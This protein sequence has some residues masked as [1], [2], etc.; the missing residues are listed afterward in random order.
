MLKRKQGRSV[1]ATPRNAR[2]AK[3]V[4]AVKTPPAARR[5][6]VLPSTKRKATSEVAPAA[7]GKAVTP[8][9]VETAKT[10]EKK[11]VVSAQLTALTNPTAGPV[12][13]TETVK[14]LL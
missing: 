14:T 10:D 2:S 11:P 1:P 7:N 9:P 8:V 3:K 4:A 5:R 13:L 12:D 6:F